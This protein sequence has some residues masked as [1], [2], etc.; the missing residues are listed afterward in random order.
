[1]LDAHGQ[2]LNVTLRHGRGP[3]RAFAVEEVQEVWRVGEAWWQEDPV[4]RT[5]Y[6][7]TVDGGRA[8]TLF[9]DDVAPD[10]G[11]YEQRY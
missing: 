10:D 2:P 1:M 5:Y 4:H 8:L 11:W 3:A 9:H 7:V 6:R